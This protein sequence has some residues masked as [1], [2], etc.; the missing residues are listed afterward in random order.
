MPCR[1]FVLLVLSAMI[2]IFV[3]AADLV[4]SKGIPNHFTHARTAAHHK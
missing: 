4:P 3:L 1:V 2:L